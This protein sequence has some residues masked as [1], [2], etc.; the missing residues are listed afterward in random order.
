MA[1][2]LTQ[3][4]TATSITSGP[5]LAVTGVTAAIGDLLVLD[6]AAD[7]AGTAGASAMGSVT[8]SAGNAWLTMSITNRTEAGAVSDGAT[9]GQYVSRVTSALA[10]GTVTIAFSPD[11]TAKAAT[12]C[13]VQGNAPSVLLVGPGVTGTGTA[14]SSGTI[15][16]VPSGACLICA[17]AVEHSI[18]AGGEAD[19]TLG[20]WG[21]FSQVVANSGAATTSQSLTRQHKITTGTGDQSWDISAG[22]TTRDYA[23]NWLIIFEAAA[24]LGATGVSD[25][26]F[27]G[28]AT[29][30]AVLAPAA[31]GMVAFVGQATVSGALHANVLGLVSFVAGKYPRVGD[32]LKRVYA[33][34]PAGQRTVE[35]LQLD[36]PAFTV[37][38]FINNTRVPW[39]FD[40]GDGTLQTFTPVPFR[41]TLPAQDGKGQQ[42]L[43]LAIDNI[44]REAMQALEAAAAQ[45]LEPIVVTVR[46]YLNVPNSLPQNKP[47]LVLTMSEVDVT[48]AAIVGTAGRSDT[49]NRPFPSRLYRVDVFPGLNR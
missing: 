4:T 27:V 41:V 16:A 17:I 18:A 34:A 31:I 19:T 32:A 11:V 25:A 5:T 21:T 26:P 6:V 22:G 1:L 8:D 42:D 37:P 33:S 9:L 28:A 48:A 38:F 35:T 40:L 36:H 47:P 39:T 12:I 24:A 20:A 29:A 45:P 44:G 14:I 3:L 30:S 10:S 15:A 49:L 13:K 2:T 7:N 43:Q 23:L 46:V